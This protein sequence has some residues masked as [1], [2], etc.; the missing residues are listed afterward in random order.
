MIAFVWIAALAPGEAATGQDQSQSGTEKCVEC[1]RGCLQQPEIRELVIIKKQMGYVN[2][3]GSIVCGVLC[4][5]IVVWA[6]SRMKSEQKRL[7]LITFSTSLGIVAMHILLEIVT[8]P[9]VR[10]LYWQMHVLGCDCAIYCG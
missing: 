10:D 9:I 7:Y 8:N 6:S 4:G 1:A 5:C 3:G 2:W